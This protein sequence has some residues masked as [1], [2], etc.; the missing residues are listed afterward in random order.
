MP[1]EFPKFV[2]KGSKKL[3]IFRIPRFNNT[4]VIDPAVNLGGSEGGGVVT[5]GGDTGGTG[6]GD[7][8]T[9]S[10]GDEG[11]EETTRP[12][13]YDGGK[14]SASLLPFNLCALIFSLAAA[15]IYTAV[16]NV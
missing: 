6:G 9:K 14:S 10:P 3:F 8:T 11:G 7:S 12:D 15:T 13:D 5:S 4:I 16:F 1:D 2:T